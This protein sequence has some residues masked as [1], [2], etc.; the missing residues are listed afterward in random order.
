[1]A[2]KILVCMLVGAVVGYGYHRLMRCV[3]SRCI[4]R[5]YPLVPISFFALLGAGLAYFG[6]I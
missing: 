6:K 1:M 4:N 3:G 2:L 5:R